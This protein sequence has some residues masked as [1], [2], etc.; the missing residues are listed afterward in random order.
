MGSTG[1][2][3]GEHGLHSAVMPLLRRRLVERDAVGEEIRSGDEVVGAACRA[4]LH[5]PLRRNG[6]GM[7]GRLHIF[8]LLLLLLNQPYLR[9]SYACGAR[10]RG[11]YSEKGQDVDA[12]YHC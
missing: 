6:L 2:L 4:R 7:P 11:D 12:E 9:H 3:G 5:P 1:E 8:I 10:C